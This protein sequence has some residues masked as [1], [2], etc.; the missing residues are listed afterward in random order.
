MLWGIVGDARAIAEIA[1]E[2]VLGCDFMMVKVR[3]SD[4]SR[5]HHSV[6]PARGLR[7]G[8]AWKESKLRVTM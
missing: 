8:L 6:L 3:V 7:S 4:P 5:E 1:P 2:P